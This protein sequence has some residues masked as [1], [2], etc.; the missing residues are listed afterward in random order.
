MKVG[1]Q[2]IMSS[3][4]LKANESP[5]WGNILQETTFLDT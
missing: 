3:L 4:V 2:Y 5:H 1:I